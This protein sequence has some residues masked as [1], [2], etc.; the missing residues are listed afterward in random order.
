MPQR[1]IKCRKCNNI[2][3]LHIDT[4][5][6]DPDGKWIRLNTFFCKNCDQLTTINTVNE[7]VQCKNCKSID[8]TKFFPESQVKCIKCGR[9]TFDPTTGVDF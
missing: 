5:D 7:R 4:D 9:K 2:E 3:T 1:N 6:Q 8:L